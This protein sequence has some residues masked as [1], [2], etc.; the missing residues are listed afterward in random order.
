MADRQPPQAAENA[1]ASPAPAAPPILGTILIASGLL[2]LIPVALNG[3]DDVRVFTQYREATCTIVAKRVS[4]STASGTSSVSSS[5][6]SS[7]YRPEFTMRYNAGGRQHL[8]NGYGTSDVAT[9]TTARSTAILARYAVGQ[10]YRCW[11]DPAHADRVVLVR[12]VPLLYVLTIVPLMA[13]AVGVRLRRVGRTARPAPIDTTVAENPF[14]LRIPAGVTVLFV[15]ALVAAGAFVV[16]VVVPAYRPTPPSDSD[17]GEMFEWFEVGQLGSV[18]A[19]IEY[20]VSPNAKDDKG[21]PLLTRTLDRCDVKPRSGDY[22]ELALYLLQK[23]ALVNARSPDSGSTALIAASRACPAVIVAT[24]IG[25]GA[26]VNDAAKGGVTALKVAAEHERTDVL[27][28]LRAA[29]ALP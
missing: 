14:A 28:L 11:Y 13:I 24:L 18:R 12:S 22:V 23:G 20:G 29:G 1:R 17:R 8:A 6:S 27:Q 5:N 21:V 7:F 25:A 3:W 26:H 16:F 15:L 2:F 10:N 19:S 4:T 9:G